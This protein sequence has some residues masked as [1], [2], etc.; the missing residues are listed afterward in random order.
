MNTRKD[1][2]FLCTTQKKKKTD[3][4]RSIWLET[5][6]Q[7]GVAV[8]HEKRG[9]AIRMP[10]EQR[11]ATTLDDLKLLGGLRVRYGP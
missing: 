7:I 1:N 5:P 3:H 10:L 4:A 6:Q 8:C 11:S 2:N 9:G